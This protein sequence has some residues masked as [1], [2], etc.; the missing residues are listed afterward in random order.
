MNSTA[1]TASEWLAQYKSSYEFVHKSCTWRLSQS[2]TQADMKL[3]GLW[4]GSQFELF[5]SAQQVLAC[6]SPSVTP[7]VFES[8]PLT[9]R[10]LLIQP[11]CEQWFLLVGDDYPDISNV[12]LI[13]ETEFDSQLICLLPTDVEESGQ[14]SIGWF[15]NS[16]CPE[17]L[18]IL[19]VLL[20]SWPK[21][22][23]IDQPQPPHFLRFISGLQPLTKEELLTLHTGSLIRQGYVFYPNIALADCSSNNHKGLPKEVTLCTGTA[24][25]NYCADNSLDISMIHEGSPWLVY[26]V[27]SMTVTKT[28]FEN[29]L[30]LG[31]DDDAL[32]QQLSGSIVNIYLFDEQKKIVYCG[33]G[34][35]V[36]FLNSYA[37][38]ISHWT[39]P[40]EQA[41][42]V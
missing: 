13:T 17:N 33:Q 10:Q 40:T 18:P 14:Q 11:V 1:L 4:Q 19:D 7:K 31:I 36:L 32:M 22:E 15:F 39:N 30:E 12:E 8:L 20:S 16:D 9:A 38:H 3:M 42:H 35:I 41:E 28:Q 34:E 29:I 37:V 6:V 5:C 25:K 27:A 24:E 26:E 23:I 2:S 21:T